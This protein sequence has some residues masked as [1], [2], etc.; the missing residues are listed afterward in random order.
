MHPELDVTWM[1]PAAGGRPKIK[2]AA[3]HGAVTGGSPPGQGGCRPEPASGGCGSLRA[4]VTVS[5]VIFLAT[6]PFAW[7]FQKPVCA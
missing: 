5:L 3:A 4:G 6:H 2:V 1:L 7:Q